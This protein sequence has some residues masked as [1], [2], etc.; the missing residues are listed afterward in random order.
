MQGVA[1]CDPARL[2]TR[3]GTVGRAVIL[4]QFR[5]RCGPSHLAPPGAGSA[6]DRAIGAIPPHA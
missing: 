2:T 4:S 1:P 6:V 5:P 3:F